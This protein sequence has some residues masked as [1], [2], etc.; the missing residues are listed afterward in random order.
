[1]MGSIFD[2]V[3]G[4]RPMPTLDGL[5]AEPK[6]TVDQLEAFHWG[7]A[8]VLVLIKLPSFAATGQALTDMCNSMSLLAD[9][10]WQ[11]SDS[12]AASCFLCMR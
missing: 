3:S 9:W 6:L 2:S 11:H 12:M 8:Q 7:I 5:K 4:A 10:S 1:M